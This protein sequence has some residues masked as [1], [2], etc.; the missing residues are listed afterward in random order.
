MIVFDPAE[1]PAA[2]CQG[3]LSQLIVPR[4]IAMITTLGESGTVNVAPYSYFMPITGDPML[5]AVTMGCHREADGAPK[6]TLTNATRTGELVI[7][8]TT[9]RIRDHIETAAMEVP[10]ELSELE[11]TG[12]TTIPSTKVA[13]PSLA[14][15]PAHLECVVRDKVPLG[16]EAHVFSAVEL[17]IAE[18][19]CVTLDESICTDD[20]RVDG[21]ALAPIGRLGFPHF[22][23]VS[24]PGATFTLDRVPWADHVAAKG[25]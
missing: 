15:S 18:V 25:A 19:V 23:T 21:D 5:V 20:H 8:V 2:R 4:P 10:T 13:P 12:W 1:H 9:D 24:A 17:V 14:E 6:D 16:G 3:M 22:S 11:L 7:N